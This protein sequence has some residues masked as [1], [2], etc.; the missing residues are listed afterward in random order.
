MKLGRIR[1]R[2]KGELANAKTKS[3]DGLSFFKELEVILK[4]G[5]HGGER[6]FQELVWNLDCLAVV[7]S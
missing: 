5:G 7:G 4:D 2:G 1:R 3:W 6:I